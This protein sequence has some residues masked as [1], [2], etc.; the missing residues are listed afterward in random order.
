MKKL[1]IK[2]I[3]WLLCVT[4]YPIFWEYSFNCEVLNDPNPFEKGYI[5]NIKFINKTW[6]HKFIDCIVTS[7]SI[8]DNFNYVKK[9]IKDGKSNI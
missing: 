2:L 4:L 8:D 5:Y 1:Y 7:N 9:F 6:K 3:D